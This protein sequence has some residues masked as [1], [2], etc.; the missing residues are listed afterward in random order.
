MAGKVR[1]LVE[2]F[3]RYHARLVVPFPLRAILGK[4]ELREPLGPDRRVAQRKLPGALA[5][6]HAQIEQAQREL[7][8]RATPP[9]DAALMQAIYSD[10]LRLDDAERDHRDEALI[11]PQTE[12]DRLHNAYAANF[13]RVR[14]RE[15]FVPG[16]K[17]ALIRV[18]SGEAEDDE[19]QALVGWR[20]DEL[21]SSGVRGVAAGS[22]EWRVLARQIAGVELEVIERALERDRGDYGGKPRLNILQTKPDDERR[23]VS[24]VGLLEAYGRELAKSGRGS[25]AL[26]RWKPCFDALVDFVGHDDAARLSKDDV[27]RW[28]RALSETLSAKTIRDCHLAGLKAVLK[29]AVDDGTLFENVA[30]DVKQRVPKKAR[31]RERGFTDAEA[32]AILKAADEYKQSDREGAKLAAAKRWVPWLQALSGARIA[33]ICQLRKQDFDFE[34]EIPSMTLTPEAGSIKTGEPRTIPI[35]AQLIERR[36]K[37]FIENSATGALF[38]DGATKRKEGAAHPS[39]MVAGRVSEWVRSLKIIPGEVPPTH[40]WRHRMKTIGRD[41]GVDPRVIDA[42]QG[43]APRTAGDGYG[44][45]SLKAMKPVMDQL[46]TYPI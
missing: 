35:H 6:F 13:S 11:G 25:A 27:I 19:I 45:V 44:G 2:R 14:A 34:S 31:T 39:K 38:Y 1:G 46:P 33:E 36:L 12:S 8:A 21:V 3:G 15:L 4:T 37:T 16:R 41:I 32:L 26:R 10:E 5:R 43:H 30:A 28:K 18:A 40:G 42:I 22:K 7:G 17:L 9:G 20:L 24:L 23:P 29:Q